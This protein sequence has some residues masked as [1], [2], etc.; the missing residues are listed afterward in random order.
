MRRD[1]LVVVA[2]SLGLGLLMSVAAIAASTPSV[3]TLKPDGISVSPHNM[4]AIGVQVENQEVCRPCH[5][6]HG[7]QS[8][9]GALWNHQVNTGAQ[10]TL[11]KTTSAYA[12]LDGSSK[13][14]LSC[15]D[16]AIAVD[17]YG[18]KTN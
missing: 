4:N 12:G 16:G 1:G 3:G 10:Y 9:L 11:Y 13:L 14:C 2:V 17:N 18:G 8:T 5:T 15:H 6:P 7:A